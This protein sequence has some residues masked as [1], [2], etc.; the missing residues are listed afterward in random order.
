MLEHYFKGGGIN[1]DKAE[2]FGRFV[3]HF[4]LDENFLRLTFMEE[5][6]RDFLE[7][8]HWTDSWKRQGLKIPESGIAKGSILSQLF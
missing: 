5:I 7:I 6:G 1:L 8:V 4:H 3:S 2:D